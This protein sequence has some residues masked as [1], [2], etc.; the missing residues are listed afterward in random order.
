MHDI[1]LLKDGGPVVSDKGLSSSVSDHLVHASG[2]ETG[3]DAI[4]DS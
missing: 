3:P 4:R 2:A 1:Q